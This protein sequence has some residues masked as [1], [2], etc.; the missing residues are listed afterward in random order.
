[1]SKAPLRIGIVAGEMSGDLLG[2]GLLTALRRQHPQAQIDG[3]GG[4]QMLAAGMESLCPLELLS[5]MGFV[6][7]L[8]RYPQLKSCH[9]RLIKHFLAVRPDVFI[10]IDAPDF[11]LPLER[12][13][14]QAGI[15][16]VHYVSPT[17]WAWRESRLPGILQAC[18]L[19]LTL[20]PFETAYYEQ[21][22]H[23]VRFVGHPLAQR[24]PQHNDAQ[25]AQQ[26]LQLTQ[27][28]T[29]VALLP[30]SRLSEVSRLTRPFLDTA[31][32]LQAR[33]PALEFILPLANEKVAACFWQQAKALKY[34][35]LPLHA[36]DGRSQTAMI[37]ADVVLL[38]SGTATLEAALCK[39]PMV[40][41]YKLSPF[42]YWL[43]KKLVKV[44]FVSQP[45]LLSNSALVPEFIQA[46]ATP[47][48][49]GQAVLD[50]L[51]QP[52]KVQATVHAFDRIHQALQRDSDQL[53]AQA[54][55]ELVDATATTKA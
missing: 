22:G 14:K 52:E 54:V 25:Q 40:V 5:V 39:R 28:K 19:M 1:M 33:R 47:E 9:N 51:E 13:L 35:N 11:N 31:L 10:G 8:G 3:I 27:G 38:A 32:W 53:A 50:W 29:Y 55:L 12:R 4:T 37:A 6:E 16:T 7:V 17:V 26:A 36:L 46:Q 42:T 41:A 24:I 30:G 18:D 21:H 20:F 15:P 44:P 23:P 45:N 49:L 43:A 34:Q 48:H 2:A